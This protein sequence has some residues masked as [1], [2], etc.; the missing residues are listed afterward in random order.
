MSIQDL[1][2]KYA[3]NLPETHSVKQSKNFIEIFDE[4]M[5]NTCYAHVD[6]RVYFK[7]YK[8]IKNTWKETIVHGFKTDKKTGNLAPFRRETFYDNNGFIKF[9][10]ST[11]GVKNDNNVYRKLIGQELETLAPKKVYIE[12]KKG[13][14]LF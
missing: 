1:L 11:D 9:E 14:E 10:Q 12:P 4:A 3:N 2:N 8:L 6:G 7:E 5:N 13:K